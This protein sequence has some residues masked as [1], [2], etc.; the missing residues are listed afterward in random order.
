MRISALRIKLL[1]AIMIH[2]DVQDQKVDA[3]S[4]LVVPNRLQFFEYEPVT[5]HCEGVNYCE[6]LHKFKGK[7]KSCSK[8]NKMTPTGSSCSI[9][10]VYADNSGEYWY[11]LEGGRRSNI[12][13]LSVTAGPVILVSPAVPALMEETVTLSCR[14]KTHSSNFKAEFY[15][16]RRSIHKTSTG[17]M[18]IQRVSKSDEG[19]YKCSISG[20]GESPV[21]WLNITESQNKNSKPNPDEEACH[22]SSAAT[23]IIST[24]LVSALLVVVGLYHI[25]KACCKREADTVDAGRATHAAHSSEQKQEPAEQCLQQVPSN[26]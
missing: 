7:I 6:V 2:L 13:N 15:K 5:F 4:L 14:N 8:T 23:R 1:M 21:S 9:Q 16:N 3:V 17:N 12:I 11:E 19:H 26:P 18:T 25:C 20:A 22:F 24:I 10:T